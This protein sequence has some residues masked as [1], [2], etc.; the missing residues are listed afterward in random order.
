M[1]MTGMNFST[2][3]ILFSA[4]ILNCKQPPFPIISENANLELN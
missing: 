1:L 4:I 2:I 3:Y